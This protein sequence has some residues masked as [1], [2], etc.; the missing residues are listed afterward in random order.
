MEL[1]VYVDGVPKVV[2]GVTESTTC[3]EIVVALAHSMGQPGRYALI[4]KFRG[5]EHRLAANEKPIELLSQHG[6]HSNSVVYFLQNIESGRVLMPPMKTSSLRKSNT[7]TGK[8]RASGKNDKKPFLQLNQKEKSASI[9]SGN[10]DRATQMLDFINRQ[11][12]K[13]EK[14]E[15]ELKKK[16]SEI[17]H[18]ERSLPNHKTPDNQKIL[19]SV[20]EEMLVQL[21]NE[22]QM[23]ESQ[24]K[25]D[26]IRL[27]QCSE[28]LI[29]YESKLTQLH[30]N[31]SSKLENISN[32]EK[33]IDKERTD[34]EQLVEEL[35]R[36]QKDLIKAKEKGGTFESEQIAIENEIQKLTQLLQKKKEYYSN[37]GKEVIEMNYIVFEESE[38]TQVIINP[39]PNQ[40]LEKAELSPFGVQISTPHPQGLWV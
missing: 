23:L 5:S 12:E 33:L 7:F 31:L 16:E 32:I 20:S 8:H 22:I 27:N 35:N 30:K 36:V 38:D 25:S 24:K 15:V 40:T 29:N 37:L 21:D 9:D 39:L 10:H 6:D 14:Q 17:R 2:C 11:R 26:K 3:Q 18:R 4:K 19:P 34:S 13:L 28:D 1:K